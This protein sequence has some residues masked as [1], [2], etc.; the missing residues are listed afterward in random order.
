MNG[1]VSLPSRR[2][3]A[4]GFPSDLLAAGQVEQVVHQ[5]ERDAEVE[6]V[7]AQRLPPAP[8]RRVAEHAANLRA[9]AE[10]VRGLPPDD[11]EVLVAR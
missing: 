3:L 2:S 5:L 9:P 7:L 4:I 11:L 10:E 1:S 6:A 8:R